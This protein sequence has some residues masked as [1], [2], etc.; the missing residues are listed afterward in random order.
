MLTWK[1]EAGNYICTGLH[2]V[3]SH[4]NSSCIAVAFPLSI[5]GGRERDMPIVS[6][7]STGIGALLASYGVRFEG[8]LAGGAR[9]LGRETDQSPPYIMINIQLHSPIR[10]HSAVLN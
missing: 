4:K 2:T 10:L 3:A 7:V 6:N 1:K 9:R 5:S 8:C